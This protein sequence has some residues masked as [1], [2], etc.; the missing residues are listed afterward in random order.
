MAKITRSYTL[1]NEIVE[2]LGNVTNS[3]K[4]INELLVEHFFG[5]NKNKK[6]E[7][8]IQIKKMIIQKEEIEAK[9]IMLVQRYDEIERVEK[10]QA[11]VFKDVP[12]EILE[13][14]NRFPDMTEDVLKNRWEELYKEIIEWNSLKGFY[15]QFVDGR[16][17]N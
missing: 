4:L 10:E 5:T 9:M 12:K 16:T 8:N 17:T 13:D 7:I 2:E 11:K 3:S 15:A 6:E 1:D 14:F